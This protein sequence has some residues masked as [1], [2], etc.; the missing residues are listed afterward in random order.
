ML[1]PLRDWGPYRCPIRTR[2]AWPPRHFI[3]SCFFSRW[4]AASGLGTVRCMIWGE[5]T[6][7][8]DVNLGPKHVDIDACIRHNAGHLATLRQHFQERCRV[9]LN[10]EARGGYLM[11]L[12]ALTPHIVFRQ[13]IVGEV[14]GRIVYERWALLLENIHLGPWCTLRGSKQRLHASDDCVHMCKYL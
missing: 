14:P 12:P 13:K 8:P 6:S 2:G 9:I 3:H 5:P 10:A 7:D 4:G 1:L 11:P